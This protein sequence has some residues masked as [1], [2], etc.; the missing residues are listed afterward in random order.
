MSSYNKENEEST[1]ERASVY[2]GIYDPSNSI[3]TL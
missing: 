2:N 3:A 1:A